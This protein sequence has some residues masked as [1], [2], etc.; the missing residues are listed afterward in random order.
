MVTSLLKE[1][2]Y[3]Q[4]KRMN[5]YIVV[6]NMQYA[7]HR[8]VKGKGIEKQ[9]DPLKPSIIINQKKTPERCEEQ[10]LADGRNMSVYQ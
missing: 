1:K 9:M 3:H 2:G 10:L 7:L 8:K 6:V 4:Y 5:L